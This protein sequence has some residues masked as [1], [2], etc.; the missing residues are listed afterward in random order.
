[1]KTTA[2]L[3]TVV[4]TAVITVLSPAQ[5]PTFTDIAGAAGVNN[6]DLG[7]GAAFLDINNDGFDDIHLINDSQP[8]EYDHL[9]LNQGDLTFLDVT[10]EAGVKN[11]PFS[12]SVRIIDV[13]ND[14]WQ[15]MMITT[16]NAPE[17]SRLYRN[18][19]DNTFRD[20]FPGTGINSE[21]YST[22]DWGDIDNDG[23][24][25]IYLLSLFSPVF[26]NLWRNTGTGRFILSANTGGNIF[27][28]CDAQLCDLD[29]DGDLDLF[30]GVYG[31]NRLFENNYPHSQEIGVSAG[32]AG[33]LLNFS[34]PLI[35]DYNNDGKFD[36]FV[37]NF[38]E[39]INA[40]NCLYRQDE[41]MVFS[42]DIVSSGI[43]NNDPA[44]CG[45]WS[46]LDND[47]WVDLLTFSYENIT[48]FWHNNG[49]G[50]FTDVAHE[51]GLTVSNTSPQGVAVGDINNDG[52]PDIYFVRYG[53]ENRL[54]LNEGNDNHWLDISLVGTTSN[55]LGI[56]SRVKAISGNIV[57][58]RDVGEG[59]YATSCNAPRVHLGLGQNQSVDTLYVYWS[60]GAIDVITEVPA[61]QRLT[62]TEGGDSDGFVSQNPPLANLVGFNASPNP[63]NASTAI[64]FQLLAV[65][66]VNLT[67]YDVTG[68]EVVKL[69]EGM[70]SAGAHQVVFDGKD[71][72]SGVYF[73]R[74][75]T[76]EFRQTRKMLLV[77]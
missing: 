56:G 71:L 67:I 47:G 8:F 12:N 30:Q 46:D 45:V 57:Q 53:P 9:F 65:S 74:L 6:T 17:G 42:N 32:I 41:P 7:F 21:P 64:S 25:D 15:D 48:R 39:Y 62:I 38:E 33:V 24:V 68:R 26:D 59:N 52:F 55:K 43:L 14:G 63:F 36:I 37:I 16:S 20:I 27:F 23:L 70:K 31:Y 35:A 72:T 13:D 66:H 54:F 5:I 3:L 49:N 11:P 18:N 2:L 34:Y 51:A 28:G 77:K 50:T 19:G 73:V 44:V 22:S 61:D 10:R 69:M 4:F 76:G 60:S 75:E 1:M 40:S 58:W 29:N